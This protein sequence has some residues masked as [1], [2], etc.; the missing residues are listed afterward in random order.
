[1]KRPLGKSGIEV[2]AAGFG[3]WPIGGPFRFAGK[4]DGW[5]RVDDAESVRAIHAALDAGMNYID[6]ADVY[7][8]GRSERVIG[9]AIRGRRDK[10]VLSTKFGFVHDEHA[11][12]AYS[13]YDVS[14]AYIW[15]ACEASLKRLQTDYI[16]HYLFHVGGAVPSEQ[17][18]T[19][20]ETL[21]ALKAEGKIRSYGWS[22][23]HERSARWFVQRSACSG[24]MFTLNVL[25][26]TPDMLR[27]CEEEGM[28][29]ICISP[30]AMGLLSGKYGPGTRLS[31]VRGAGHEWVRYF[32]N[33]A[34]HPSYAER[35]AAVRDILTSEGRSLVQG[36]LAWIWARSP[37]T[38]AIPGVKTAAQAVELAQAM[39]FGPLSRD[40]MDEV[41][42]LIGKTGS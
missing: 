26:D 9:Q 25:D 42:R 4:E 7:G 10:V 21:D 6:T 5:G 11:Q 1:M 39:E 15:K 31:D 30:L 12:E 19:V 23:D 29:A 22:T 14:A 2:S 32:E 8:I 24:L 13:A 20:I 17:L 3:G 41:E 36:A 40:R 16:D 34:P 33:G 35:M 27:L 18:Q 38:V 28:A 37:S